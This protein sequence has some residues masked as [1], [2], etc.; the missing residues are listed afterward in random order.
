MIAPVE[1]SL[2]RSLAVE[3]RV[4][5][6]L[7]MREIITRFGRENLGVLWLIAEP[8]L[9]TLGVATL[10]AAVGAHRG[11]PIPVVAFAITGY[12]SVL[13]WR[14]SASRAGSAVAAN[15]SLLYHRNVKIVDVL[16]TRIVLEISGATCSFLV[17]SCLSIYFGWMPMPIDLLEVLFGWLMLAWFGASLAL[18]IGAATAFSEIV[19]RLW[20]PLAYLLF[21]LSGAAFM[22]D[23]MP[24]NM[25]KIVLLLPMVHGT[26]MLREGYFGNAVR[27]HF[28]LGYMAICCLVLSLAGLY[29]VRRVSLRLEF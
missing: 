23:W 7:M 2:L 11:S 21:P 9:F 22:V 5:Y 17:L 24:T 25:Q 19:D 4:L 28:D 14:N 20:H 18:L 26:E 1:P 27:T 15:K 16:L 29:V 10:W 6:A 12:S 8:M 3:R 13:M